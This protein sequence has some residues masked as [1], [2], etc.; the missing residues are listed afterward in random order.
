MSF[1][2][3]DPINYPFEQPF[4]YRKDRSVWAEEH[5]SC[6]GVDETRDRYG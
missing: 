3:D 5:L 4:Q 6:R 2:V 1:L